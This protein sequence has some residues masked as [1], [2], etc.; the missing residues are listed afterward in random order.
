MQD[1]R[2]EHQRAEEEKEED[3]DGWS[4]DE[5]EIFDACQVAKACRE[6]L[7]AYEANGV[8][9]PDETGGVAECIHWKVT[10]RTGH[11]S[12]WLCQAF[13][14]GKMSEGRADSALDARR[15]ALDDMKRILTAEALTMPKRQPWQPLVP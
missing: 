15:L 13:A 14:R 12:P 1:D 8:Y 6:E 5:G 7:S 3:D 2:H 4:S 11:A 9:A 10:H